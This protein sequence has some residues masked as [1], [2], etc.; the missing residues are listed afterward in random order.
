M[1]KCIY[2]HMYMY[3]Y[4]YTYIHIHIHI[5]I[6]IYMYVYIYTYVYV[7]IYI[8][9]VKRSATCW[10]SGRKAEAA[11]PSFHACHFVKRLPRGSCLPWI[12]S[13]SLSGFGLR[14]RLVIYCQTTGVSA[15]HAAHCATYCTA[16]RPLIRAFSGWIRIG[17]T[18]HGSPK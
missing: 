12:S 2:V 18:Q 7:Y 14:E 10:D 3:I 13:C 4:T 16:C 17:S 6:H 5:H 1:Y 8:I 11:L 15:A 9:Y